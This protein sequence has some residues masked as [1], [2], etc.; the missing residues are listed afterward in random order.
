M[1]VALRRVHKA[2]EDVVARQLLEIK[3]DFLKRHPRRKP[4]L[5]IAHRDAGVAHARFAETDFGVDADAGS[6]GVHARIVN[7]WDRLRL[8]FGRGWVRCVGCGLKKA[9]RELI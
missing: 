7:L 3:K 9:R 4:A 5:H 8:E 1:L 2:G 6:H